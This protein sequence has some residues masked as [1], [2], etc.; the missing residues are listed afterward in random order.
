VVFEAAQEYLPVG[1][2]TYHEHLNALARAGIVDLVPQA[3][4]GREVRLR[5]D[6]G[7]VAAVCR[8]PDS[9]CKIPN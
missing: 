8:S 2:T 3:G 1:K 4:R 9:T 5:Y 6:A 7:D